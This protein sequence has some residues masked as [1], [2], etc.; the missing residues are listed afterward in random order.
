M[1]L[2]QFIY[3][4]QKR[5]EDSTDRDIK[6]APPQGNS[7]L[8]ITAMAVALALIMLIGI[9]ISLAVVYYGCYKNSMQS[10]KSWV[11]MNSSKQE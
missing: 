7:V 8:V 3:L 6:G 5:K 11:S 9:M 1:S 4:G 2:P 10:L